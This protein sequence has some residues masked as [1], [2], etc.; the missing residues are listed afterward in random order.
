MKKKVVIIGAGPAG[1]TTAYHILKNDSR[2]EVVIIEEENCVGGLSKTVNYN[3][4][5]MDLGGHRF[6]SKS[7]RVNHIWQE[8]LPIQ[9]KN[10]YDDKVLDNKKKL[11]KKGP[12]PEKEDKV[13]LIRN[14]ISR[15]YYNKKF[16]DYPITLKFKVFKNLGLK[17]TII[18]G[19][20]YLKSVFIKKEENKLK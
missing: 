3:N 14:R 19:F 16:F 12:D 20:S 9:G 13:F 8:I 15:I 2:H 18:S 7:K 11:S 6:F 4:N 10:S 17:T 1:L 5:R